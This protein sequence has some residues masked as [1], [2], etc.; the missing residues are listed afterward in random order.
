MKF[1]LLLLVSVT[2]IAGCQKNN[3]NHSGFST[4]ARLLNLEFL[5]SSKG[6]TDFGVA[7]KNGVPSS[8]GVKCV[9][10]EVAT[11][12][13]SSPKIFYR[14]FKTT[15]RWAEGETEVVAEI[16]IVGFRS[17]L[18]NI[19]PTEEATEYPDLCGDSFIVEKEV[20]G[21]L[22]YEWTVKSELANE[23][24]SIELVHDGPRTKDE[25]AYQV[26]A[27]QKKIGSEF[28][29]Y[30]KIF[31]GRFVPPVGAFTSKAIDSYVELWFANPKASS[32]VLDIYTESYP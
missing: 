27:L 17:T 26:N 3:K 31:Y 6:Q 14:I 9:K 24:K 20:G 16:R 21:R 4:R 29:G 19:R 18:L 28:T 23:I 10:G 15:S 1:Y 13:Y 8:S 5:D 25:F 2:V 11:I 12:E 7:I 30:S 22:R 32:G